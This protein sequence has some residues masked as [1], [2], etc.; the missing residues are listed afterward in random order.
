MP[1]VPGLD[2]YPSAVL[3]FLPKSHPFWKVV[4]GQ[5]KPDTDKEE[6]IPPNSARR[7]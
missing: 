5:M 1:F 2:P 7:V 6:K 4:F 3:V